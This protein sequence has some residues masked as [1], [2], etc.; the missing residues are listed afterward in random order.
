M[1]NPLANCKIQALFKAYECFFS[2]LFKTSF[3][4]KDFSRQSCI[5]KYFSS[6]CEPCVYIEG[7]KVYDFQN[8]IVFLSLKIDFVLPNSAGP[9]KKRRISSG[10]SLFAKVPI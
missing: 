10:T 7:S 6:L 1:L 5:F 3:I 8:N 4:F 9:N 2:V